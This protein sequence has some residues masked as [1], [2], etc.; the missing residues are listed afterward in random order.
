M[1]APTVTSRAFL[2]RSVEYGESDRVVTLLTEERGRI[3]AIARGARKSRRRFG[4]ALEA[5]SLIEVSLAPSKGSLMRLAEASLIEANGGLARSLDR[6]EGASLLLGLL[7]ELLPE[8]QPEPGAFALLDEALP[9]LARAGPEECRRLSAAAAMRA[10]ALAGVGVG[11]ARCNACGRPVP[12]RRPVHF[13]PRRGGVICTPCGGGPHLLSA[14][15]AAGLR[16]LQSAPLDRVGGAPAGGEAM[17][18]IE[19]ALDQF[20]HYQIDRPQQ[21][22]S[23][24]RNRQR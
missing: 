18:E 8:D 22:L 7:R 12:P 11:A 15:A 1:A 19:A 21:P 6:I 23:R 14:G 5:F 24:K 3:S 10:L 17:D 4:G 9:L 13:D 20:V 2:L 16:E